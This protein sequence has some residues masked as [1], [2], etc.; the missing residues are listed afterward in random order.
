MP[1]RSRKTLHLPAK[2]A[3]QPAEQAA[4]AKPKISPEDIFGYQFAPRYK[5][6]DSEHRGIVGFH[7]PHSYK[8][9]FIKP[10]R[11]INRALITSEEEN[12]KRIIVSLALK[13][14]TQSTIV[15]KL[16]SYER[17]NRTKKALWSMTT[18]SNP[19]ISLT[20][21]II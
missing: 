2:P 21:S 3:A 14:A 5:H 1:D 13:S 19:C 17:K 10:I 11:K 6:L 4:P 12:I 15:R 16:S 18:S 7:H 9:L 20:I 8:D